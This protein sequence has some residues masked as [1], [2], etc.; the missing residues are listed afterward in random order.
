MSILENKITNFKVHYD[1]QYEFYHK[2]LNFFMG[3]IGSVKE[4]ET[5][6][7]RVK[8]FEECIS[9]FERKY[10]PKITPQ[11]TSYKIIDYISDIIG[12]RAVCFYLEDVDKIRK[13][14]KKHFREINVTNK[15]IQLEKT[16]NKFGYRSLHLDLALKKADNKDTEEGKYYK[17]HFELQIRTLIQDAWSEL[18]HKIKYKKSIPLGLKRRIN[19]LSA[20]FELADEE[21]INIQKEI[22]HEEK[23]ISQR[24]KKGADVEK[25]MPLDVFRFLFV[26]IKHFPEYNFIEFKV[27]GFVQE[28]LNMN[29]NLT[30]SDL[31]EA[32]IKYLQKT[33]IIADNENRGLNPYTK[34]RYCLYLSN[35]L[36]FNKILSDYQKQTIIK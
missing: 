6:S 7:G 8:N 19:R 22:S 15:N 32:L 1:R 34:I 11:N 28:L 29:K 27:D 30:E 24:I 9:K 26:A 36:L 31:N 21:F 16:E 4:V 33:D 5:V 13:E 14:L 23:R 10:L 25:N 17:V 35:P 18:D 12:I 2:A 3:I 20:L